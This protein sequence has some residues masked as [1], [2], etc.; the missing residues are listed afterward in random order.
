LPINN[1]DGMMIKA[2]PNGPG[3]YLW[4]SNKPSSSFAS[5]EMG[6]KRDDR[7]DKQNVNKKT[8]DVQNNE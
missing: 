5:H 3:L 1:N 6:D 7:N 2:G 4:I 8:G